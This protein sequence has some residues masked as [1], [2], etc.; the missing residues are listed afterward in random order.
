M[1]YTIELN[2]R[3]LEYFDDGHIYLVDGV[4]VP[5]I[6]T[7]LSAKFCKRYDGIDRNILRRASEKG[8][9]VHDAIQRYCEDGEITDIPEI[10]GFR[11]LQKTYG[12]K[13]LENETPVI[14]LLDGE[15]ISAG[16]LDMVIQMNEET[17]LADIK[18]TASLDKEYLAY[19]L[20]LYRIAYRQSYG[21]EVDFLRGIH[22]REDTRKFV[23]IPINEQAIWEFLREWRA[24][25]E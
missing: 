4:I 15:P 20:N 11:F 10:R 19:Q 21:V 1:D 2:G 25:N 9:A 6:T 24:H 5:S 3:T 23:T 18:R 7:I 13:V 16:R 8:T 14:L 12:F 22:L 17:G